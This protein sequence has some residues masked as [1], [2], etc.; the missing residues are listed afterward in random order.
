MSSP[1]TWAK[2]VNTPENPVFR[3]PAARLYFNQTTSNIYAELFKRD[4]DAYGA[5]FVDLRNLLEPEDFEDLVHAN[6]RGKRKLS[7]RIAEII[8]AEWQ[9][10]RRQIEGGGR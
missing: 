3:L 8:E 4:A 7:E 10:Y 6:L 5:R 1:L 2:V 9:T